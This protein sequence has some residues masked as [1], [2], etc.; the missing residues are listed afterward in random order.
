VPEDSAARVAAASFV[1]PGNGLAQPRNGLSGARRDELSGNARS[2]RQGRLN[3]EEHYTDTHGYTEINFVAFGMIGM[4]FCPRLLAGPGDFT[5]ARRA[6]FP[7]RPRPAA[8]RQPDRVEERRPLRQDHDR[9]PPSSG[10]GCARCRPV[11]AH[12]KSNKS[13]L[14]STTR[15]CG[16]RWHRQT[17]SVRV[18][19][20]SSRHLATLGPRFAGLTA[21]T[22]AP[23]TLVRTGFCLSM[24]NPRPQDVAVDDLFRVVQ[25]R[26]TVDTTQRHGS[27]ERRAGASGRNRR[28][29]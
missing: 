10:C 7:V 1:T 11:G 28:S 4:R 9:P 3:L 8:A 5:P 29:A 25:F 13:D 16:L 19:S 20:P 12:V 15:C 24:P 14:G 26:M 17:T 27:H 23:R 6:G 18:C 21:L 22:T 2:G